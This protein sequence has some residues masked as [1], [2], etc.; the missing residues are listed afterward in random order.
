MGFV[1][2]HV[3][4]EYSLL[5]GAIRIKELVKK[6]KEYKMSA[7][8]ITDHGN[9]FGAINMYKECIKEGIKPI[10]GCEVYV[11]PRS[12]LDKQGKIDTEPNHLI[13]LAM[14]NKGYKNLIKIVSEGYTSGFYYKPRVDKELLKT[15]NEGI[16]ALSACLAGEV[17]RK[18]TNNNIEGAKDTIKEYIDIF[19]K[20]RYFL[21][22]QDNKL[23]EQIL[24]N[25]KLIEL[26]KEFGVGL[27]ATNDCHYLE[28][29][30]YDFHEVLLCI[31]TRTTMSDED[32]MSFKVNE[33]YFKS[34]E[35]MKEAFKNVPEAIENT[36][37]IANMCNVTFEF[38]KTILPEFK[39]NEDITHLEFFKRL[40]YEGLEK[41]YPSERKEE[42]LKRL[43]YEIEV[44][45]KM[46]YIDY[47]LIV[48]DY[49]NYAKSVGIAVGPGR[50]SGAGSIAAYLIGITNVDPL[51]FNL[52][53]ERFLNPERVSMPD[54]DVDFCYER[55]G[56]VIDYVCR[57]YGHDHVAQIITFGTMAA[58]AAIR[59]VA[60]AL[61]LP[62]QK[63]DMIAKLVPRDLKITID[64]ALDVSKE[65][66]DLYESDIEVKNI[67]DISKKVEGLARH[68]STHAAG[69]VITKEP[70]VNYVPLYESDGVISTEYTMTTLEE[71]G[72]LKMD[73]LGLR[74]LTV[75]GDTIKLIKKI[76]GIDVDFGNMDDKETFKLLTEGNTLGVFQMESPGFRRV[77]MELKPTTIEDIIVM[78][79]LYRPGP[80]DQI[81]RYI[82]NKENPNNVIYTHEALKPILKDTYGCMVYQ[83][84]VMQIFR[85]LAGYSFGRADLVRRAMSKKKLD[86]MAKER[87]IFIEG[88]K[89]NNIDEI[90]ANKIFDEMA[91]F[92]KYAFNKSHAAC[93]A[94]VAY[95]TAYLKTHFPHEFMA[96]TMNSFLGNLD[97][98]PEYINECRKLGIE[99]LKPDINESY[100]K[101]AV[102]NKKIRFALSSIKNVGSNAIEQIIK[103]RK[104]NGEFLNF[105]D[106]CERV[107][108]DTVNK[109][110]I[111]SLIKAGCFDKI[112]QNVT[113]YD[114]LENFESIVDN[115]N[116]TKKKNYVNQLN[117]FNIESNEEKSKITIAKSTRLPTKKDLL[118][119]EKEMIGIYVS[120]HPLDEYREY[121]KSNSNVNSIVLNEQSNNN[122]N[123]DNVNEQENNVDYDGKVATICGVITSTKILTTKSARQM[124]FATLEDL[125]SSI[126]LVIFPNV[127]EKFSHILSVDNVVKVTGK[128]N[129]KEN[130]KAKILV[131]LVSEIKLDEKNKNSKSNKQ[132]EKRVYIRIPEGKLDMEQVVLDIL[133][134]VAKT[135]SGD[136]KVCLF[137][138]GTNKVKMLND[139][140]MLNITNSVLDELN[141]SF[142]KDNVKIK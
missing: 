114:M 131:S 52:I 45:D 19:G 96:A 79:S 47:F 118:N 142:G 124:M 38:G 109:K 134:S 3:H 27:V 49:I 7:V 123:N 65:L 101:F 132:K 25:S 69:V 86:V 120:G 46:G 31:Q 126:E 43:N 76:H 102:I 93:Y 139:N 10:I 119:M 130:E 15:Y 20:D 110:C 53:F 17:A 23:R 22:I 90:S 105:V 115:V 56:E 33:F 12:R 108:G 100:L 104:T 103:E 98:I 138:D 106:F 13:L 21:E 55:R 44:I 128:I 82:H 97:K 95:Q 28:K 50:G 62:Y 74:T 70:V 51:K 64:K 112:E 116:E 24:V 91:E 83:E 30:D 89:K 129:I 16:I 60:R 5:D 75:I 18:I 135:N 14:N 8:A 2:L 137:Y 80:M 9:M 32:R 48:Q 78:I 66:R 136:T 67:I 63:A 68:A 58:R 42:A 84:Q 39:I 107:S 57:K 81:P 121:I 29:E 113:R 94:V 117:F 77:M 11:A 34:Q 36:E 73:F 140:Y 133:K 71:L 87:E 85:D 111:E 127:Y 35:E 141:L 72:L 1:H 40:C 61:D 92:A 59:D 37:K 88:A 41:K 6:A 125:Y 122:D 4:T 54:F 99:V 26:S